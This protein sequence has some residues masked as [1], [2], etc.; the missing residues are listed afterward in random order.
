[1]SFS[2]AEQNS[3]MKRETKQQLSSFA[4]EKVEDLTIRL[5]GG[6]VLV[7]VSDG[8][9]SVEQSAGGQC[10]GWEVLG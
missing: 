9:V 3:T 7:V 4:E 1:M 2:N 5:D 6:E 8:E 10:G